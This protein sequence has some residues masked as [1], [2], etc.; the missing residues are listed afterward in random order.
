MCLVQVHVINTFIEYYVQG[1][2]TAG[3]IC[4]KVEL[5]HYGTWGKDQLALPGSFG[6]YFSREG[7]NSAGT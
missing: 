7:D 5:K 3:E 2:L 1:T 6:K 4:N